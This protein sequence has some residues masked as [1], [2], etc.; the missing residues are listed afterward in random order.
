MID[1]NTGYCLQV[2][3]NITKT[4]PTC[5]GRCMAKRHPSC[6]EV[7]L[8]SLYEYELV[9]NSYIILPSSDLIVQI[10]GLSWTADLIMA[11]LMDLLQSQ[12]IPLLLLFSVCLYCV[13]LGFYRLYLSPLAKFPGP[14]LAALT[15]WV[16]VYHD[17]FRRGQYTFEIVKMHQRYGK[18]CFEGHFSRA[19]RSLYDTYPPRKVPSCE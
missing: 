5:P 12:M 8:S 13:S 9:F 11:T 4:V 18:C 10:T 14:K 2:V 7:A 19:S 1:V 3:Q 17:V 15:Y 16:E 6:G